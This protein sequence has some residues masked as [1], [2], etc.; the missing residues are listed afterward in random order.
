MRVDAS[1]IPYIF[2]ANDKEQIIPPLLDRMEVI[3]MEKPTKEMMN[4]ITKKFIVPNTLAVY[5]DRTICIEE[6]TVDLLVDLLWKNKSHSCRP[7]QKAEEIL[8][9]SAYFRGI[10][11]NSAVRVGDKDVQEAVELCLNNKTK[12]MG[13]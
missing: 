2:T 1:H 7:Y 6:D 13:F 4:G 12:T 8:V 10:E 5:S 9:S 3:Q 11:T